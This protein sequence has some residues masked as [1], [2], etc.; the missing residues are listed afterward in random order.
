MIDHTVLQSLGNSWL[1]ALKQECADQFL[2]EGDEAFCLVLVLA[3]WFLM[4]TYEQEPL[5][6]QLNLPLAASGYKIVKVN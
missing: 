1:N 4:A 2:D 6:G 5:I 3:W